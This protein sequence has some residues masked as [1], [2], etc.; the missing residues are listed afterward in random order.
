MGKT[1]NEMLIGED[2]KMKRECSQSKDKSNLSPIMRKPVLP[3]ANNK[4]ADQPVHPHSLIR[5]FLVRFL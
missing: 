2:D 5:A 1:E 4:G 3:Y